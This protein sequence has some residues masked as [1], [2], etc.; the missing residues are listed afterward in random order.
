MALQGFA[1][2]NFVLFDYTEL[3]QNHIKDKMNYGRANYI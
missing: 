2:N 3:Q 1:L